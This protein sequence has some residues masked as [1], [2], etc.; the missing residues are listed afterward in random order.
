MGLLGDVLQTLSG[1]R[2]SIHDTSKLL[3]NKVIGFRGITSGV[4]CSTIVQ[5]VAS[6]LVSEYNMRVCVIDTAF[7]Y[8]AQYTLLMHS[9]DISGDGIKDISKY[10]GSD[11]STVLAQV[12]NKL[13]VVGYYNKTIVDALTRMD[14]ADV[15]RDIIVKLKDT[16]DVILIDISDELSQT[17]VECAIQCNKI[18]TIVVPGITCVSNI[19]KSMTTLASVAVPVYKCRNV[20]VNKV[21]L[22]VKTGLGMVLNAYTLKTLCEIELS[23]EIAIAGV[24][25]K[26]IYGLA[27]EDTGVTSF[28]V[29]VD[30]ICKDILDGNNDSS[31]K[32]SDGADINATV[33]TSVKGTD[34]RHA[35]PIKVNEVVKPDV[36]APSVKVKKHLLW[37]SSDKSNCCNDNKIEN[38]SDNNCNDVLQER[39]ST[40]TGLFSDL[41][42]SDKND[43][44]D[45]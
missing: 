19:L 5:N 3:F 37:K 40:D 41:V 32:S 36:K 38:S 43:D 2:Y 15:I 25:G 21:P 20:I 16:F 17:S 8:N 6:A 45:F 28:N 12:S 13:C 24:K 27:S 29:A 22:G 44:I 39:S 9:P 42:D 34:T 10:N 11:I 31:L 30:T 23:N 33:E 26:K 4:G 35:E 1:E 18:Y 7:M 14:S